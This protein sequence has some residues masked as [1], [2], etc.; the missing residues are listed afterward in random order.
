M[1]PLQ[2]VPARLLTGTSR[3]FPVDYVGSMR[4]HWEI[5]NIAACEMSYL[6]GSHLH[7]GVTFSLDSN[8]SLD[9][10]ERPAHG[11]WSRHKVQ[12]VL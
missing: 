10:V 3:G 6:L 11:V 4:R 2:G 8:T 5:G 12:I 9:I 7:A 1:K